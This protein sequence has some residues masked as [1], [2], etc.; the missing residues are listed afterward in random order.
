MHLALSILEACINVI[1][2]L[3]MKTFSSAAIPMLYKSQKIVYVS[4]YKYINVPK[5]YFM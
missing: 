2:W 3:S 5:Q 1:A 4:L